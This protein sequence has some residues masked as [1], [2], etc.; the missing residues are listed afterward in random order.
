MEPKFQI[1]ILLVF[2]LLL[3]LLLGIVM[4]G[5]LDVKTGNGLCMLIVFFLTVLTGV[6]LESSFKNC[7]VFKILEEIKNKTDKISN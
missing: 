5:S 3:I 6:F 4:A 7:D 1:A 2:T